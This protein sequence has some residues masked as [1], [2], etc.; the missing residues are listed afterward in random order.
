MSDGWMVDCAGCWSVRVGVTRGES[1]LLVM[2]EFLSSRKFEATGSRCIV[3]ALR[4]LERGD[5]R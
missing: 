4:V 1:V 3:S 2:V 5:S